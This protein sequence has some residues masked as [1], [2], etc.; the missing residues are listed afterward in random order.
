M[1]LAL[2]GAGL[3]DGAYRGNLVELLAEVVF[4]ESRHREKLLKKDCVGDEAKTELW[5]CGGTYTAAD[6]RLLSILSTLLLLDRRCATGWLRQS[7]RH[8]DLL[9]SRI[10]APPL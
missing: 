3:G 1:A 2:L 8:S 4:P 5:A 6:R 10:T 9:P 7:L